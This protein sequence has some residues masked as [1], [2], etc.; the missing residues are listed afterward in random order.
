LDDPFLMEGALR[1]EVLKIKAGVSEKI[2]VVGL[3]EDNRLFIQDI[4]LDMTET[5]VFEVLEQ[6]GTLKMKNLVKDMNGTSR[7][8][9]FFEYEDPTVADVAIQALNGYACG[10]RLLQVRRAAIC[11]SLMPTQTAPTIRTS[12]NVTQ[13]PSSMTQ[14]IFSNSIVGLQVKA[15]RKAGEIPS[16]V[17][18]LLNCVFREDL[19]DDSE[20][21]ELIEDI[22]QEAA[23]FGP[24][25]EVVIPRPPADMSAKEGVGKVFLRYGDVTAA[26]KAQSVLNGRKWDTR[27]VV[28]AAFYPL[29]KFIQEK[30]VLC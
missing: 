15:A 28:C 14:K 20:Y 18:Q 5:Q 7:G 17:V 30:Y 4:P 9:G 23:K 16:Q 11:S 1:E 27:R 29:D 21:T 8:Y 13:L 2:K 6:F 12:A 10:N 24:L 3:E 19:I 22:R 25:E 26:R